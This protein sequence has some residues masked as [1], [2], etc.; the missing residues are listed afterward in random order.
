MFGRWFARP[1]KNKINLSGLVRAVPQISTFHRPSLFSNASYR[2]KR[3]ESFF[4]DRFSHQS[5]VGVPLLASTVLFGCAIWL[6]RQSARAKPVKI[7]PAFVRALTQYTSM[8]YPFFKLTKKMVEQFALYQAISVKDQS[9]DGNGHS[10]QLDSEIKCALARWNAMCL[11]LDGSEEAYR[12]LVAHQSESDRLTFATYQKISAFMSFQ[13]YE[14]KQAWQASCFIGLSEFVVA[15]AKQRGVK[16]SG[17]TNAFLADILEHCPEIF[18]VCSLI[19][20]EAKTLLPSMYLGE[21]QN[22]LRLGRLMI[23]LAGSDGDYDPV[24]SNALTEKAACELLQ[25]QNSMTPQQ[26][27]VATGSESVATSARRLSR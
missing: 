15:M 13:S 20:N 2:S 18:P 7:D 23:A 12:E 3:Q 22:A 6:D 24:S 21:K 19:N 1:I 8:H 16:L 10:F 26:E 11:L 25:L 14:A 27:L 9:V 17:D 5:Q 4:H